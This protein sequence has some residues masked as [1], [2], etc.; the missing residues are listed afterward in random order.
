MNADAEFY[1]ALGRDA[2]VALDEAVLHFDGAAHG[3]YHAAE[4]DEAAVAGTLDNAPAMHGNGGVDQIAAQPPQ[5]RTRPVFVR[6]REPAV[7]YNVRNQDRRDFPRFRHGA[8]SGATQNSTNAGGR[9]RSL[10][11]SNL[12]H[13]TAAQARGRR[14]ARVDLTRSPSR[15]GV[16]HHTRLTWAEMAF[17]GCTRVPRRGAYWRF[18]ISRSQTLPGVAS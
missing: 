11:E 3:V 18:A 5:T 2:G 8:P 13:G 16:S 10:I 9:R 12:R 7:A 17:Q 15:Q 1:A 4:L 14:A 6:A